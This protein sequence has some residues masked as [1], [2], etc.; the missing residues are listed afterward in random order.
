MQS[1]PCVYIYTSVRQLTSHCCDIKL[2]GWRQVILE[3][4]GKF[5][6][7]TVGADMAQRNQYYGIIFDEINK[8]NDAGKPIQVGLT[9]H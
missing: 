4:F 1:F 5:I 7:L 9:S 3:E 8:Q 6:N 2:L